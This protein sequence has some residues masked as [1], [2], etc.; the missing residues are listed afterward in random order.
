VGRENIFK[1]TVCNESLH[2]DSNDSGARIVNIAISKNP[3]VKRTMFPHRN[4]HKYVWTRWEDSQP[5][6]SHIDK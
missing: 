3:A 6:Y 1:P 2:Q 4:I 5:D